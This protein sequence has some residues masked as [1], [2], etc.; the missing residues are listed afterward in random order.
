MRSGDKRAIMS[1]TGRGFFI[2]GLSAVMINLF[3]MTLLVDG[4]G[5]TTFFCLIP[6]P[7]TGT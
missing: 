5:F 7:L 4:L 2:V 1:I 3:L 6:F